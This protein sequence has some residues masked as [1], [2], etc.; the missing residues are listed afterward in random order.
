MV[1]FNVMWRSHFFIFWLELLQAK[2]SQNVVLQQS[3]FVVFLIWAKLL[4]LPRTCSRGHECGSTTMTAVTPP[5]F[6]STV[7]VKLPEVFDQDFDDEKNQRAQVHKRCNYKKSWRVKGTLQSI[8]HGTLLRRC[9]CGP[10]TGFLL[11]AQTSRYWQKPKSR[12]EL[13]KASSSVCVICC[14][15]ASTGSSSTTNLEAPAE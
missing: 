11:T 2:R 7:R 10:Y 8:N 9:T 14:G 1:V 15:C 12:R 13:D 3:S 5:M 4:L 6:I